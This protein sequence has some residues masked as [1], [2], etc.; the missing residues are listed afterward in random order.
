M[1]PGPPP[2]TGDDEPLG[3]TRRAKDEMRRSENGL[4]NTIDGSERDNS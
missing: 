1:A 2:A 3:V 4:L